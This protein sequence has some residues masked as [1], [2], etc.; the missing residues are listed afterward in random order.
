MLEGRRRQ[1][2][3]V[4]Q[5]GGKGDVGGSM[6]QYKENLQVVSTQPGSSWSQRC[7]GHHQSKSTLLDA[8]HESIPAFFC[9][10]H[11]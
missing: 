5:S 3:L 2:N 11:G 7:P 9:T 6:G 4:T 8:W 1:R 10:C